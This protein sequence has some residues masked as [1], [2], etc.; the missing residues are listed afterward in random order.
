LDATKLTELVFLFRD[1]QTPPVLIATMSEAFQPERF[2]NRLASEL[3]LTRGANNV[4]TNGADRAFFVASDHTVVMGSP[5]AVAWWL[6]AR[7]D[8]D[9]S[10]LE[11]SRAAMAGQGQI[12]AGFDVTQVPGDLRSQLPAPIQTLSKASEATMSIRLDEGLG[13]NACLVFDDEGDAQRSS[14]ELR[15]LIDQGRALLSVSGTQ[16]ELGLKNPDAS[17]AEGFGA[18]CALALIRE[19]AAHIDQVQIEQAGGQILAEARLDMSTS[20]LVLLGLTAIRSLGANADAEFESVV[21]QQ[22]AQ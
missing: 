9:S 13:I 21:E 1:H 18:L 2:A 7:D 12:L 17:T 4:L 6:A 14:Q 5:A 10:R 19:G 8:H 15:H 20:S 3:A 11:A 22:A 16:M